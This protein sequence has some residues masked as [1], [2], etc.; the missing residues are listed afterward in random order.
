MG[1]K[2]SRGRQAGG[3]GRVDTNTLLSAA[4]QMFAD[5]GFEASSVRDLSARLGISHNTITKRYGSKELLWF[6]AIDHGFAAFNR[7]LAPTISTLVDDEPE[8]QF[9]RVTESFLRAALREPHAVRLLNVEGLRDGPRLRYIYRT[10]IEP[11]AKLVDSALVRARR[12]GTTMNVPTRSLFFAVAHGAAAPFSL[13]ALS[14]QFD[15]LGEGLETE[16]HIQVMA[17]FIINGLTRV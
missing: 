13:A 16:Q 2:G 15:S 6:A 8:R 1:G 12:N 7:E 10:H 9:R 5:T 11:L 3:P 4:W 14:R 17:D